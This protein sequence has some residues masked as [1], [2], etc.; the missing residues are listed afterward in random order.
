[1]TETTEIRAYA[2]QTRRLALCDDGERRDIWKAILR[3]PSRGDM[4]LR[5]TFFTKPAALDHAVKAR[6]A[7]LATGKIPETILERQ[8][9]ENALIER[10]DAVEFKGRKRIRPSPNGF[11]WA[12]LTWLG[13][14]PLANEIRIRHARVE[15]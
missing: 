11:G 7:M 14:E 10:G 2:I 1:M 13:D 5:P 6:D 15:S 8:R 12:P 9:R 4:Q 3:R